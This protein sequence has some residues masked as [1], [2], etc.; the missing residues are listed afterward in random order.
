MLQKQ[1][2]RP[3]HNNNKKKGEGISFL[4]YVLSFWQ[5]NTVPRGMT[6]ELPPTYKL[7]IQEYYKST[8]GK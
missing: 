8:F 5:P 2:T 3:S 1:T 7:I 4:T 6:F